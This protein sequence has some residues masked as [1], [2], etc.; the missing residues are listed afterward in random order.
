MSITQEERE[1]ITRRYRAILDGM[2]LDTSLAEGCAESEIKGGNPM[3][4]LQSMREYHAAV[5]AVSEADSMV[6][7]ETKKDSE[8]EDLRNE[9]EGYMLHG[10]G[11]AAYHQEQ[12][13]N[14]H[15]DPKTAKLRNEI[16]SIMFAGRMA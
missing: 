11:T 9:I 13:D 1:S 14:R 8:A 16:E 7:Q 5:S 6:T 4:A 2:G 3:T 15:E 10:K 12:P